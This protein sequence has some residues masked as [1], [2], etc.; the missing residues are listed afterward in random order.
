MKRVTREQLREFG[1]EL[2][3]DEVSPNGRAPKAAGRLWPVLDEAAFYGVPGQFVDLVVPQSEADPAALLFSFLPAFGNAVGPVP[4]AMA[5]GDPHPGRENVLIVGKTGHSRKGV[6]RG[7]VRQ[8][9]VKADKFWATQ[10]WTS[11]LSSGE[12]LVYHVRDP[13]PPTGDEKHDSKRDLGIEDKRLMVVE[14]EFG[15]LLRVL[16]RDGNTL[17]PKLRQ[18][19]DH[20][21]LGS[22][23]KNDP[24][25]ATRA[26]VSV[27]A[28][29]TEDEL[30]RGID[31]VELVNGF[32]NRFLICLV[33]RS[34]L[35]PHGGTLT[36]EDFAD[37]GRK[38]ADALRRCKR[39]GKMDRSP[40]AEDRWAEIYSEIAASE[41]D[42]TAG[43]VTARADA[44]T[45]RLSVL[46]A[47]TDGSELITLQHL[48]AAWA[49]WRYAEASARYIFGDARGDV[50]A[51]TILR[52]GRAAGE[53]DRTQVRDLFQRHMNGSRIDLAIGQLVESGL[54]LQ[55]K[56]TTDGRPRTLLYFDRDKSDLGDERSPR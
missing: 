54:A 30:V 11:G 52:A 35:L 3:E 20:G 9:M 27:L 14:D 15:S 46:Y 12:G 21:N 10:R 41:T 49:V 45:L 42:G 26:H 16:G 48:E 22:L 31:R 51:D 33:E 43:A 37:F 55:G 1:L 24:L 38:V 32:L 25:R 36:D 4:H 13:E 17:S 56:V 23:T 47:L 7:R 2:K 29:I 53:L 39:V 28:H 8:P 6:S 19:W 18:A 34:K 44:H 50:V 40:D 5:E